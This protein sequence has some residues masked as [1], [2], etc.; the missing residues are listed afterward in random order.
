MT[1]TMLIWKLLKRLK[2]LVFLKLT[3]RGKKI[4]GVYHDVIQQEFAPQPAVRV[5]CLHVSSFQGRN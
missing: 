2:R 4:K 3:L 5:V 1:Q